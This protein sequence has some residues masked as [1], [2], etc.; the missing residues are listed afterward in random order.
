MSLVLQNI[1]DILPSQNCLR[2]QQNRFDTY[3][4]RLVLPAGTVHVHCAICFHSHRITAKFAMLVDLYASG[5]RTHMMLVVRLSSRSTFTLP[6]V[7]STPCL[8]RG[9][10]CRNRQH[11]HTP[12]TSAPPITSH[13]RP[14]EA[15]QDPLTDRPLINPVLRKR[16]YYTQRNVTDS[17]LYRKQRFPSYKLFKDTN[18]IYS[19]NPEANHFHPELNNFHQ[20]EPF[21]IIRQIFPLSYYFIQK[22]NH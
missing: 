15:A 3:T 4:S 10:T 5:R 8:R 17:E 16:R 11:T 9:L 21:F 13:A 20:R 22:Q 1:Y 6:C 12:T 7:Y 19:A 2:Q 18:N 14:S